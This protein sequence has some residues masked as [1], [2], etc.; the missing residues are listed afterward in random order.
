MSIPLNKVT[1]HLRFGGSTIARTLKCPGW[2]RMSEGI[3]NKVGLP[4]EKGTCVHEANEFAGR[5]GLDTTDL[6]GQTFNK[7]KLTQ[8]MAEAGQVFVAYMRLLQQH[9]GSAPYWELFSV[10]TSVGNDV[11]GTADGVVI[12]RVNRTLYVLDYKNGYGLVEADSAQF[13]FYAI[14]VL[15]TLNLWSEIDWIITVVVQPNAQHVEGSVRSKTYS[16]QELLVLHSE[17]VTAIGKARQPDAPC[18]PGTHCLYCPGSGRC[19][20][21]LERTLQL[22]MPDVVTDQL[23]AEEIS[24]VF[25]EIKAIKHQLSSI[26]TRALELSQQGHT[27][28][29]YKLVKAIV[30]AKCSDDNAFVKAAMAKGVPEVSLYQHK[31]QSMTALKKVVPLDVVNQYFVKPPAGFALATLSDKRPAVSK[32]ERPSAVGV[33]SAI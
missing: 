5:M 1:E 9:T 17:L 18:I 2:V 15:D 31:L 12:D 3:E 6:V 25:N 23:N 27:I 19:R 29:G 28:D 4:A 10:L 30:R 33:F 24:V 14:G 20:A 22:V 7:I 16:K 21:R 11:G 13:W 32:N 26:E 8:D